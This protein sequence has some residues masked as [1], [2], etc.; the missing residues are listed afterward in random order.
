MHQKSHGNWSDYWVL[1]L[2][3]PS[4]FLNVILFAETVP[5]NWI[6]RTRMRTRT[7]TRSNRTSIGSGIL[8]KIIYFL[9]SSISFSTKSFGKNSTCQSRCILVLTSQCDFAISAFKVVQLF[10]SGKL[11]ILDRH[12]HRAIHCTFI[13]P[14][15]WYISPVYAALD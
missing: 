4:S 11:H 9:H 14:R 1:L 3:A 7:R 6:L 10:P 13:T 2:H 5:K 8:H 12:N 15:S